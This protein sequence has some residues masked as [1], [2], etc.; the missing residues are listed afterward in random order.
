MLLQNVPNGLLLSYR[1][2][3]GMPTC[4]NG[5]K[6]VLQTMGVGLKIYW[7][8]GGCAGTSNLALRDAVPVA[9]RRDSSI[10]RGFPMV[11]IISR[12]K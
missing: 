8:Y 1:R 3:L 6:A 4:S 10:V 12:Y 11:P 7:P 5:S 9:Q 2:V